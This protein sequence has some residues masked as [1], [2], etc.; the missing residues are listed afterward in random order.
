MA[1]AAARSVSVPAPVGGWN[2]RDALADMPATD[3]VILDNWF[4]G[5]DRV[6]LRRGSAAHVTG[7]P[8]PVESLLDYVAADGTG[9]LWAV[10]DGGIYD[11]RAAAAGPLATVSGLS[12]SRFQ[13]V[14]IQTAGGK[15]LL[16]VNG[17]D[18]P[19]LYDGSSWSTAS[20][21]GPT[22][23]DLVWCNL[24]QR[25]LWFGARDS[26]T[27]WYLGVNAIGGTATAFPLG[28]IASLGGYVM[29]MG[30]WSRDGGAGSDD[31]ALFLTSEGEAIVYQGTDPSDAATWA[32]VGVFRIGKPI[33][34]RCMIKMG[35]DLV[36]ITQDGYVFASSI[37]SVD[38]SQSQRVALS[39]QINAAVNEAVREHG[40]LPGWQ[41]LAYAGGQMLIFNV[42]TSAATAVQH[43]F[44]TNTRR[45]CR[46]T[47]I[48]ALCWGLLGGHAHF[49]TADGRVCRFDTGTDD[50][51][52]AIAG[53]ALQAFS[54]FRMP[55]RVKAFKRVRPI[56]QSAQA[57]AVALDLNL[58]FQIQAPTAAAVPAANAAGI[59]GSSKWGQFAWGG[60]TQ[61]FKGWREVRGFGHAASL[62]VRVV[63]D[64]A[65]PSWLST[66]WLFLPGGIV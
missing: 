65:R 61:T 54:Y 40:G 47:G 7:L 41:A 60:G 39:S 11:A 12:N 53:D 55:G 24:H 37:L 10:A 6:T 25:R 21:T 17:A 31:V 19:R 49:G 32:L 27:A 64:T 43:V 30:T 57:P 15:Y 46:F 34:R 58:D 5:T 13:S 16:A 48:D 26:L 20:F 44:N 63:S 8:G 9:E 29:A 28:G 33:G 22:V 4:P 45:P 35:A 50:A 36:M 2:A 3:A 1:R 51:G 14:Q 18:A 42:P 59:W 38:R 62:R 56:F 66:D 52:T 23:A